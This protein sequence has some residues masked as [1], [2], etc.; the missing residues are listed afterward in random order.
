[1]SKSNAAKVLI[2]EVNFE[3][4]TSIVLN[5][6]NQL[7]DERSS[8]EGNVYRHATEALYSLLSRTYAAYEDHFV[9]TED[10]LRKAFRAALIEKLA[11][12]GIRTQKTSTTLGILI[13]YVFKSDRKRVMRYRYVI[14]AAKSHAVSAADLPKWLDEVGGI[15]GACKLITLSEETQAKRQRIA[16]EVSALTQEIEDR[17]SAPIARVTLNGI[18]SDSRSVLIAEPNDQGGFDII[19]VVPQLRDSVYDALV[20]S[21]AKQITL[22]KDEAAILNQEAVNFEGAVAVNERQALVAA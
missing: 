10:H 13:R 9:K 14:E 15:D 3:A 2:N 12:D 16:H 7:S 6:L 21:A 19:C 5:R 8:W 11:N 18:K 20:K 17:R 4:E 22:A 1:M